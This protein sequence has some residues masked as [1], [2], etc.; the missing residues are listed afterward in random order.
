[1]RSAIGFYVRTGSSILPGV[2]AWPGSFWYA[3]EFAVRTFCLWYKP[4]FAH[5]EM[6]TGLAYDHLANG[7]DGA[8][9]EMWAVCLDGNSIWHSL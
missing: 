9:F 5:R 6:H 1:M 3:Y 8:T 7:N 4:G 2:H